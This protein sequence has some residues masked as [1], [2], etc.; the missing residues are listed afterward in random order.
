MKRRARFD[1]PAIP[2]TGTGPRTYDDRGSFEF[3]PN[4]HS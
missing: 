4:V 3:R 2:N 1:D